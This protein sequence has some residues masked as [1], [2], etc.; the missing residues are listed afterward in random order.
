MYERRASERKN[1]KEKNMHKVSEVIEV[2]A[3]PE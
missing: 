1:N 3:E 2:M